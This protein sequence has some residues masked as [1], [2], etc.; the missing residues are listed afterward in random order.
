[1]IIVEIENRRDT[2]YE[3]KLFAELNAEY[4]RVDCKKD[5]DTVA[6]AAKDAD[7]ILLS[8]TKITSGLIDRLPR[9]K[10][11]ARYGAG[12]DNIDL[13]YAREKGIAVCN[14]PTYSAY[15]VAEHAFSLLMAVNRKLVPYDGRIRSGHFGEGA[16][17][18]AYRLENKVLGLVGFGRIARNV[19]RFSAGFRMKGIVY[20][21]FVTKEEIASLGAGKADFETLTA[22]ADYISLH[23]P[24]TARTENLFTREVFRRMKKTAVLI[25]TSRGGLVHQADLADALRNRVIRGAG[26][27]VYT[28][29][30]LPTGH[31]LTLLD[32][33][34][35]TPHIAWDSVEGAA[36]LHR[37]VADEVG[38]FL[39]GEALLNRVN[40]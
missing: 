6:E 23:A 21:P 19:L 8:A 7:V 39:R 9:L 5:A 10:L 33:A 1:M 35:L 4:R 12:V 36:A 24:L 11:L 28:E 34:V 16:A 13:E 20:D 37:E 18:P 22:Q 2:A 3:E 14:A 25:N 38:R 29:Y 30:P 40:R 27:D 17:Y 31:P 26:I 15:D 32:N